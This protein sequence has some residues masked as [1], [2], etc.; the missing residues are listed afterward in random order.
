M[1]EV[2]SHEDPRPGAL[3][4]AALLLADEAVRK[5]IKCIAID[6]P[7]GAGKSSISRTLSRALEAKG[8]QQVRIRKDFDHGAILD[9]A[10]GSDLDL[11]LRSVRRCRAHDGI[12]WPDYHHG[13]LIHKAARMQ[14]L[15]SKGSPLWTDIEFYNN[16]AFHPARLS[17]PGDGNG[18]L[19]AEG[20][21][22]IEAL[23]D[24]VSGYRTS[25]LNDIMLVMINHSHELIEQRRRKRDLEVKGLSL[26]EV[27][28]RVDAQRDAVAN[29]YGDLNRGFRKTGHTPTLQKQ[30]YR[31]RPDDLNS[32]FPH[33]ASAG[34]SSNLRRAA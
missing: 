27:N 29:Y 5:R 11:P 26:E 14:F 31:I 16:G 23:I 6:A 9:G 30:V 34:I 28:W 4:A 20:V 3:E 13:K 21:R 32:A 18:I 7:P 1:L 24:E 2:Y 15:N 19:I 22:S 10:V 25:I 8:V 12:R 33:L 17:V